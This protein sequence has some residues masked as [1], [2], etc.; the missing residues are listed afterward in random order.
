MPGYWFDSALCLIEK[1]DRFHAEQRSI[2]IDD[3][4]I[5]ALHPAGSRPSPDCEFVDASDLIA[6]PGL[7]NCH[8]HSPDNLVRSTTGDLPLELWSLTSSAGREKRSLREIYISTMLGAIEMMRSGTT[9]VL[10]HVRISPDIDGEALDAVARAWRD[11][12]MR[13]VIA[14]VMSDRSVVETMPFEADDLAGL[15][16]SAYGN[17]APLP[18]REQMVIAEAF[19][20]RWHGAADGRIRVA[21]GPSGPQRCSD[22]LLA[23]AADF[24][25]RHDTPLHTHILETRLQREM[26]FKLYGRGTIAHL[27]DLGLLTPRTN[28]VHSIWLEPNDADRIAAAD[29]TVIHNPVSNARLG[30]GY[31]PL[32]DLIGKGIRIGLGTD[33]ACCNDSANLLETMKWVALLHRLRS[34]DETAWLGPESALRLGTSGGANVLGSKMTGRLEAGCAADIT[35]FKR[36]APAFSPLHDPVRQL[37]LSESGAAIDR[38]MIA[39]RVVVSNGRSTKIDETAIWDEAQALA[40][41][42]RVDGMAAQAAT[43]LLEGPIGKMR[44]RFNTGWAEGCSCH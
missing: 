9:A 12:G 36:K 8:S 2:E 24:S 7:V 34:D 6:V 38:V 33:S 31:C 19:F 27:D 4:Q 23:A 1:A 22:D 35:F 13:A 20:C 16:L 37:V 44:S 17:R 32:P 5:G 43:H 39:G 40:D 14:P 42:R 18:A 25:R 30:S 29:A 15:D 26:G 3:R 41:K 10:D 11:S 28:L 21:I